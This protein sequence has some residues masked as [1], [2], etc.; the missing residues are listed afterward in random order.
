MTRINAGIPPKSL[1]DQHLL[2][3]H[4]E[5][6]R[7]PSVFAK[8][9][10]PASIPKQFTLG[11]GHVKFF[12]NK[13]KYTLKRYKLIYAECTERGFEIT[14]Y[15]ANWEVYKQHPKYN[16]DYKETA[17]AIE[18][19]IARISERLTGSKQKPRYYKKE[20]RIPD[21]I[22]EIASLRSQ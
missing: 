16:K 14:D 7:L 3:E 12:L 6:K 21:A 13:G 15:S 11:T 17:E 20:I 18:L 4:R 5:I 19:L 1:S 22:K 2:A 9:P 10:N 8:N